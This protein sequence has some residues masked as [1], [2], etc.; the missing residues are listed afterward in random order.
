MMGQSEVLRQK[1]DKVKILREMGIEL[2]PNDFK[3]DY[4]SH[5]ILQQYGTWPAEDLLGLETVFSC[6]G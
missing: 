5:D 4:T 1:R 2:F 6:A 3:V